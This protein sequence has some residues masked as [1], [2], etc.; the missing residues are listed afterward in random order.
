LALQHGSWDEKKL[1]ADDV[2]PTKGYFEF[3]NKSDTFCGLKVLYNS[4]D[5]QDLNVLWEVCR[6]PYLSLPPQEAVNGSLPEHVSELVLFLLHSNS[7]SA[8]GVHVSFEEA[9]PYPNPTLAA[10]QTDLVEEVAKEEEGRVVMRR[11]KCC[12]QSEFAHF[13][14]FRLVDVRN[15]NVLLKYKGGGGSLC[16]LEPRQ[17]PVAQKVGGFAKLVKSAMGSSSNASS[18]REIASHEALFTL[19]GSNI[20]SSCIEYL[21][22]SIRY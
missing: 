16:D 21:Q 14:V 10:P 7:H 17:G 11:P 6:P 22:S 3:L 18:P 15:C 19:F 8:E 5:N 4:A 20:P 9:N 1:S 12:Q 2:I 13:T